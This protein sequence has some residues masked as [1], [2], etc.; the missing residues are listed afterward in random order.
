MLTIIGRQVSRRF[1]KYYDGCF[2]ATNITPKWVESREI[3]YARI[4]WRRQE[5][6]RIPMILLNPDHPQDVFEHTAA[7]E[8]THIVQW[9]ADQYPQLQSLRIPTNTTLSEAISAISVAVQ[10]LV[11]DQDVE[12]RLKSLGLWTSA[13]FDGAFQHIK[14]VIP[15]ATPEH[16]KTGTNYFLTNALQYAYA[17][18]T[19][20][21]N[22]W[23]VAQGLFQQY[24]PNTATLGERIFRRLPEAGCDTS[25]KTRQAYI[26]ILAELNL[27]Q[28]YFMLWPSL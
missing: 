7:H 19:L 4:R 23:Q 17:K 14:T 8:L 22:Q 1:K 25:S 16:D 5:G 11:L 18:A 28:H 20:A 27:P 3:P 15:K 12:R 9:A 24:L 2:K 13:R 10:D 6:Q 26:D 21:E